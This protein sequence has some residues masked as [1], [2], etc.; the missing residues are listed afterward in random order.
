MELVVKL[1]TDD[2]VSMKAR[3]IEFAMAGLSGQI[4]AMESYLFL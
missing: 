1:A 4:A 2:G 3:V